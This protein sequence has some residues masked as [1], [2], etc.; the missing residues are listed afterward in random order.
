MTWRYV[1]MCATARHLQEMYYAPGHLGYV[2]DTDGIL[3]PTPHEN[4]F[5]V[6]TA[7]LESNELVNLGGILKT[8]MRWIPDASS[9][10]RVFYKFD[11]DWYDVF[12]A[13][14]KLPYFQSFDEFDEKILAFCMLMQ[15]EKVWDDWK[16]WH[17][18]RCEK[19]L[20]ERD[21][22][23]RTIKKFLKKHA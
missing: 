18:G 10:L 12:E 23:D 3:D 22:S 20:A 6:S 2:I 17:N 15:E 1:L 5:S 8:K 13:A 19:K 14:R 21:W 9:V 4:M 11:H 16:G 7:V